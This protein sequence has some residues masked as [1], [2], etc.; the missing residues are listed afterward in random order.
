MDLTSPGSGDQKLVIDLSSAGS[1]TQRFD[2]IGTGDTLAGAPSGDLKVT[3][4]G[5]GSGGGAVDVK[6][7]SSNSSVDTRLTNTISAGA[8]L[9]GLDV[10]IRTDNR[11][12][13]AA[14]SSNGGGGV[15]SI[16]TANATATLT[17]T[18]TLTIAAGAT[19]TATR[20][21]SVDAGAAP[22]GS[23]TAGTNGGGLGSGVHANAGLTL[24]YTT[25]ADIAGALTAGADLTVR[26]HTAVNGTTTANG[27]GG[28]LG[29]DADAT[30]TLNIGAPSTTQT[31]I[32]STARLTG[33][34]LEVSAIVDSLYARSVANSV[35]EAFGANSTADA[36]VIVGGTAEVRLETLTGAAGYQLFGNQ[37]VWIQGV[38]RNID[39]ST[40]ADGDCRCAFGEAH[41][42]AN[43]DVNTTAKVTGRNDAFIETADLTVD[44]NQFRNRWDQS[45]DAH[46]GAFVGHYGDTPGHFN[47]YRNIFWEATVTMLGEANPELIVDAN[48]T[49]TKLVNVT[50]TD[51]LGNSYG[52]GDTIA[53]GRQIR[54][55]DIQND[56]SG[57]AR[58]RAND[59]ADAPNSEIW[60]NAGLFNYQ[61]TWDY[62]RITNASSRTL[63]IHLIDVVN[64][65]QSPIITISV[66]HVPFTP[67]LADNVS[68]NETTP[69]ATFEF[70]LT[71]SFPATRIE[72]RNVL[73]G[74]VA[75]SDI[76]LEGRLTTPQPG[77]AT[78]V[79][80]ENPIGTTII[81]NQRG[82]ILAAPGFRLLRTNVLT[83]NAVGG[84]IGTHTR[85][86][87][88]VIT[89]R[90]PI[91]VELV[92]FVDATNTLRP[93]TLTAAASTDVVL[94]LRAVRR[95]TT[96]ATPF[97]V[98]IA[99]LL[100]GNDLDVVI[101]DSNQQGASA[102][103]P[104]V[105]IGV[106]APTGTYA[107]PRLFQTPPLAPND[108]C[109]GCATYFR[110]YRPDTGTA[111]TTN[112]GAFAGTATLVNSAYT[113]ADARAGR[114]I[115]IQ[116]TSTATTITF[117]ATTDVDTNADD[118][119]KLDMTTN[120]FVT[121][122]E[123]SGDLRAGSITSTASDVTLTSPARIIDAER[124][125]GLLGSDPTPTDV[126][127]V[128]ITL[129]AGTGL[130]TG[131][132]GTPGDFLEINVALA[133]ACSTRSTGS[134]R[135]RSASSSPR[136]SA[137][138]ALDTVWTRG[139]ATLTTV[140]GSI[141]DARNDAEAN[142]FATSV[143]LVA[144][145]PGASLG[146]AGERLRDRF[147]ARRSG[148]RRPPGRGEHLRDR[149]PRHAAPRAR[150]GARRRR[151][152]H[153][154]RDRHE[155]RRARRG[156]VHGRDQLQ[157]RH[158]QPGERQLRD[159][160]LP[161]RDDA[162]D[163]AAA[164]RTT[165]TTR[166]PRSRPPR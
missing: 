60:G 34:R 89:A 14:I 75:N 36:S 25:T 30:A 110:H 149:D 108:T 37:A 51:E 95:E 64:G 123:R 1:G 100:A 13:V 159:R 39:L 65:S 146:S 133:Q 114:D 165:A 143:D 101:N 138:C 86:T 52:L 124:G 11:G 10:V 68:L 2:G 44:A 78:D 73:S 16:G 113:F 59:L 53:A 109:A 88:G 55:G 136:P 67:G 18:T 105:L 147:L 83:L 135:R 161:G 163:H 129:T 153:G 92:Q 131:G 157:R 98:N 45:Q 132:I 134:P 115:S 46:G 150:R 9:S 128:N 137:T 12:N 96:S 121:V 139:D 66:E 104:G 127:G 26:S 77:E 27:Q 145:G 130:I 49:I 87:G 144:N 72:I 74:G 151:P 61:E 102:T 3:A 84:S 40:R 148:R 164:P 35:A 81:D 54:V 99:S 158:A 63:V 70:D 58:F 47:A 42:N 38:Y 8:Q 166:S 162:A 152:D 85:S 43:T 160:R 119:G 29:V 126:T 23:A 97:A 79:T 112:I 71:H 118:N 56:R 24:R 41:A 32:R 80:I 111:F 90:A 28:G 103:L 62:V 17:A 107:A 76:V 142:V 50:V 117:T 69:G 15:V 57:L 106:F 116:H 33:E 22:S 94:D 21:L 156:R 48:G 122:T 93:V 140:A 6:S 155:Q 31:I 141:V 5:S 7:A 82:S 20:N 120:G 154:P 125:D 91:P 4:S 19:L